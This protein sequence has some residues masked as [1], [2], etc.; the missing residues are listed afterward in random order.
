MAA[1]ARV[2]VRTFAMPFGEAAKSVA[3]AWPEAELI[4]APADEQSA[5]DFEAALV[6]DCGPEPLA[7][8]LDTQSGLRWLH[9]TA[10]GLP[11]EVLAR[12]AA[13]DEL[14]VTNGAGTHGRAV[15]EHVVAVTLAHLKRLPQLLAAQCAGRWQ[16]PTAGELAGLRAG[17]V[18]LGDLGRSTARLLS[19]FGTEIVGLRRGT[20]PVPEVA[21]TFGPSAWQR[22]Y[23]GLDLLVV[24]AP[25][26]E[27][28]HGLIGRPQLSLLRPGALLVNVGRGPVVDESALIE[29]LDSGRLSGAALDVFAAEPLPSDSPLWSMPGVIVTPHCA[30]A[31]AGTERR[32]LDLLLDNIGRYRSGRA[33]RNIVDPARGY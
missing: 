21:T 7:R 10:A 18:G 30:D 17:I 31:T 9:T 24:A 12:A 16:P 19:A 6:W 3:V 5:S 15:A 11:P 29:A 27:H 14:T 23:D 20:A 8:F 22:F 13:R 25:L 32:C 33:L 28:T 2:R 4:G 1:D 26:T